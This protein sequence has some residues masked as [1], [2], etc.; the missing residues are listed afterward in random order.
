MARVTLRMPSTLDRLDRDVDAA[1]TAAL[2]ATGEE[3]LSRAKVD[4]AMAVDRG[5][6]RR[7]LTTTPVRQVGSKRVVSI[8]T[9]GE[10]ALRTATLDAGRRPGARGPS[11]RHLA[12]APGFRNAK[13]TNLAAMRGGWIWRKCRAEVETK[14][15]ELSAEYFAT[16]PEKRKGVKR[17]T[18]TYF[19][20][21]AIFVLAASKASAIHNLG[22]RARRF[23]SRHAK[24]APAIFAKHFRFQLARRRVVTRS[25]R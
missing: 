22:I 25:G 19:L 6:S 9:T 7:S 20:L 18:N 15:A 13:S 8:I 3:L 14:A 5:G 10:P 2:V 11:W 12:F 4:P 17:P 21:R 23:V 16:H 24:F 1:A